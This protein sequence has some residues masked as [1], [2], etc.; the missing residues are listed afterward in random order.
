MFPYLDSQQWAINKIGS[1]DF[2]KIRNFGVIEIHHASERRYPG[3]NTAFMIF[4]HF[5]YISIIQPAVQAICRFVRKS[6]KRPYTCWPIELMMEQ[7][8]LRAPVFHGAPGKPDVATP[9]RPC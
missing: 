5:I 6:T 2:P 9:D 8:G 4:L 1:I 3:S 7:A